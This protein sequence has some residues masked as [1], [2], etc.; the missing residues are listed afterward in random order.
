MI[1]FRR[2]WLKPLARLALFTFFAVFLIGLAQACRA[3]APPKPD[4]AGIATG[5]KTN[6]QD[7]AGNPFVPPEPTDKTA[8]DYADKKKAYDEYTAQATKEPLAVKLAD[9]VGHVRIG[10]NFGWTLNTGYLVLFMQAGFALLTC[11]LVRKKNAG[12]L[13]MLNFAAYVFAF[14]AYYAVGFAFQFGATAIN[15]A[16]SNLAGTPTLNAFLIGKGMWGFLGGKGFF[17]SGPAYDAGVNALVLFEVV[18]METAGYIIVGAICERIT[19]GAFLLCELFVGSILY[20]VFGCWVW[21][22]GWLSQL[23]NSMQLGHGYCDFAGS[24][25]V[26]AIGGFC[27]MAL[28]IILGPRIGKYGPDGKPRAFP[29]HNIAFVVTGTFILLF[30]WMGFNPG[31][32][33]G[34]TDLRISVVAINTNLAAIAG[35]ASALCFWYLKFGTPDISMAC[36]G[37]LAGLVAITAPCAFVGPSSAIVI[38]LMAGCLVCVGVLFNDKIKVDDPCGA[39]SVHG[40]CGVLGGL[41]LGIFA[42]GTYGAGWNGVGASA[43]MGVNGRGVTGLLYGDWKQFVCQLIGAACC[44]AWAFGSTFVVFKVVNAIKSMR[45]SPEVELEGLDVPQFGSLAYPDDVSAAPD[46]LHGPQTVPGAAATA[47]PLQSPAG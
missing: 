12:H 18:F 22:G 32:T 23:G 11:G 1:R 10:T 8:S 14:L 16:P 28:A 31:S 46:A 41:C 3:D 38:G 44:A 43:Y 45:V 34:A 13:M 33:L 7:A 40:Y 6:A 21:G 24:T 26:H 47:Q 25:V 39:I 30:G 36:N 15:N 29:A 9:S 20:P 2:A 42:D 19:F 4:P 35:A 27:A 37:M 5:D 17:L